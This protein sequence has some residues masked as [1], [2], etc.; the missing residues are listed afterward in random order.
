MSTVSLP[1]SDLYYEVEGDGVPVLL[2][3]GLG[4]DA[5][6]W[7]DQVPALHDVAR[8]IRYD[9]R[10]FGRSS[11]DL[12]VEYTHA[13]DAWALLDH[14][15]VDAA[16][17][18]GLSMGGRIA[19]QA[20][21]LH[22]ERVLALVVLDAVVDGVAWDPASIRG[23]QAIREAMASGGL[24]AAKA[25]WLR[26]DFFQPARRSPTVAAR[27]DTMVADYPGLD[28]TEVDPHGPHEQFLERLPT[29]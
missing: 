25:A 22:P 19:V 2:I 24:P 7:D 17:I 13:R 1:G 14:L 8:L 11:R 26:H 10:G 18:V 28:W 29:L 9:V 15:G 21:V 20:T 5:R 6:M 27:L 16:V 3:H 4:L 12:E 23:M